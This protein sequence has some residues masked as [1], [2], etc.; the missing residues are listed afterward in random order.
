MGTL[1]PELKPSIDPGSNP[2]LREAFERGLDEEITPE[3]RIWMGE[4]LTNN[5]GRNDG[6]ALQALKLFKQNNPEAGKKEI[7]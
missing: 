4:W 6:D 1:N 5:R 7:H 2:E 3:D